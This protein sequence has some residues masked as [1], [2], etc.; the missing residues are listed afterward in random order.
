M[1][2][3]VILML[4]WFWLGV[5][6]ETCPA[7]YLRYSREHTYCLPRKS[8]C[9]ILQSGVT[10]SDIEIIVREHNL[11]RSKV[12]TGKETQYSMPKASNMLQM[13]WD[14]EL[15]A[16]AQ[17]HADQ[18]TFDHDCGDCRR[19]KNFGV[20]QNLF[21]RTS[22]SGQPSPP[23]WAEAV[24]DWYKEIKDFQKK[25]ID[26]FIDGK[27]PPQT[28]HFTQEIWADTWRVGCGYSAYKKGSGFEELYTCNYGPGGNIKTR[29][30]YE[31]GNPCTRCPLNSCC[32]NSCSGGTSYPGLCR[33]S[34]ENAPQYKRPEGLTFYCSFNN[35]PDC[36]AT[37]TGADKWEVSKTLSG[38]YIGIVLN[39]GESSTLSFTKSFKV[40]TAPLCFTSYYRTG[41]QVKGEKSAGIFTEI[42]K[43]PARPDKSFPTVLTSSSMSFTKFTK[44]LGWT[45]ET[46]F[47]VSFSVPKGKPA[48]YLELTDLSARAGP[49]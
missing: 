18:C 4:S 5:S 13:V 30:I 34:G 43:L 24:K 17:K 7:I 10:K 19:V 37:T 27:G 45:M 16:V 9:T 14:D 33:I 11:L 22:P 21:Q 15:A 44:K 1:Q 2:I 25:Q 38:S 32:G 31:K 8:S 41:P 28:G 36:A 47:S 29:P 49:C 48:Q 6:A 46:T 3:R 42:F 12:A 23:T 39:G 20:G 40:P 26:G 35:E